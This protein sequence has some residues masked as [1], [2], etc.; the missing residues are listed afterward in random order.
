[1]NITTVSYGKT[2]N[3]GDYES[4]RIDLTAELEEGDTAEA[5]L[6]VLK[7]KVEGQVSGAPL[8]S[9]EVLVGSPY[10]SL[11]NF[12]GMLVK[13]FGT[14]FEWLKAYE[15]GATQTQNIK[16][17]VSF[18]QNVFNKVK[19]QASENDNPRPLKRVL[20]IETKVGEM[21]K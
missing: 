19:Q 9:P 20:E 16:S 11:L 18:N 13:N 4:E 10:F 15:F 8:S 12:Q 1:M 17:Y 2:F 5:V 21:C 6:R 14:A 7:E 3:L